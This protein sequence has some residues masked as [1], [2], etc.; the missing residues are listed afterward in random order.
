M[1]LL[2]FET[3]LNKLIV[4]YFIVPFLILFLKTYAYVREKD[5]YKCSYEALFW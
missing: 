3:D 2:N 5:K 1:R 4:F